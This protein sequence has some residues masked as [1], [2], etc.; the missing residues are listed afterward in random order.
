M[1]DK[2]IECIINKDLLKDNNNN[3]EYKDMI[4]DNHKEKDSL[5]INSKS[6]VL[7]KYHKKPFYIKY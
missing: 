3:K 7:N 5:I 6:K 2:P 1:V 4:Y